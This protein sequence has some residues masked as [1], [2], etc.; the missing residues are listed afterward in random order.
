MYKR[1]TTAALILT[2]ALG[3]APAAMPAYALTPPPASSQEPA[4]EAGSLTL[5]AADGTEGGSSPVIYVQQKNLAGLKVTLQMAT[6]TGW[7]DTGSK[8]LA[9]DPSASVSFD[10]MNLSE[11]VRTYRA[12]A[13]AEGGP[14]IESQPLSLAYNPA[15]ATS[16]GIA[17]T[18]KNVQVT[19]RSGYGMT[20][21]LYRTDQ[22]RT[23]LWES[24][25]LG[26]AGAVSL[27]VPVS[28]TTDQLVRVEAETYTGTT[29]TASSGAMSFRAYAP[30]KLAMATPTETYRKTKV[31][32]FTGDVPAGS[33]VSL[34]RQAGTAWTNVWTSP[35]LA[36]GQKIPDASVT[37][38]SE[39]AASFR[40]VQTSGGKVVSS[41]SPVAVSFAKMATALRSGTAGSLFYDAEDGVA[42]KNSVI[43]TYFLD[44]SLTD[45]TG[46][47]QELR[48]G[49]WVNIKT[50]VFPKSSGRASAKPV[51]FGTPVTAATTSATYRV[52]VP[53]TDIQKGWTSESVTV[54]HINPLHY[55]GYKQ[56][57]YNYMKG[58]CPNQVVSVID[59]WVSYTNYRTHHIEMAA[60]LG[61][62][63]M[64]QYIALHECA[65]V[66]EFT[67][68]KGD[69]SMQQRLN[70]LFAGT[71]RL[72]IERAADC[73][74]Y[75]MGADPMYGG[76]Y[77]RNCSASQMAAARKLVSGV[78]P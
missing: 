53:E 31:F 21:R 50:L 76:S 5:Q 28:V 35:V 3:L 44:Y 63:K 71:D 22:G 51:S 54:R 78:K 49:K 10:R 25:N 15:P 77:L 19:V 30:R 7:I 18:G 37:F 57:A 43:Q 45:R 23:L 61:T 60:K 56:A 47:L 20:V 17:V 65:H 73:M 40:A 72:G 55:T 68:Y 34:Q 46:Y 8:T 14:L 69:G 58:Y 2:V 29:R 39:S 12:V 26:T 32:S 16:V 24:G 59:G 41:T 52:S 9:A 48:A 33:Q 66:R 64:M 6:D 38:G 70:V 1:M 36:E 67:L 42:A 62:G 11:G 27:K 74:A 4:P 13:G 75:A